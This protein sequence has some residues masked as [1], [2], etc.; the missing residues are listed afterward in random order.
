M[1]TTEDTQPVPVAP[2]SAISMADAEA[3]FAR[4]KAHID[5]IPSDEILRVT[6]DIR[7]AVALAVGAIPNLMRLRTEIAAMPG[8]D[9]KNLDQLQ[10]RALAALFAHSTAFAQAS[11]SEVSALLEEAIPLRE[12]LLDTCDLLVTFGLLNAKPVAEVRSGTGNLDIASDLIAAS[13]LLKQRWAQVENKVPLTMAQL[14]HAMKLGSQ[15]TV[16][17]GERMPENGEPMTTDSALLRRA[18]AY[19]L[20]VNTYDACQRAVYFLRW[21]EG[22]AASFAPSIFGKT[23]RRKEKAAPEAPVPAAETPNAPTP[24]VAPAPIGPNVP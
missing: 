22:D 8:F 20:F 12:Q 21:D 13:S 16:K 14:T 15:L 3:A 2:D 7:R 1:A 19:T 11:T 4:C 23:G 5:S 10:D 17:L 18:R 6:V 24:A 9:L